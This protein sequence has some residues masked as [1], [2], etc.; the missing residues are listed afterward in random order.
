MN[1]MLRYLASK[2]QHKDLLEWLQMHNNLKNTASQKV[3]ALSSLKKIDPHWSRIERS[4]KIKSWATAAPLGIDTP[5]SEQDSSDSEADGDEVSLEKNLKTT[6]KRKHSADHAHAVKD[7]AGDRKN[8]KKAKRVSNGS[9]DDYIDHGGSDDSDDDY[10]EDPDRI[11]KESGWSMPPRTFHFD[12]WGC[13]V[14]F[15]TRSLNFAGRDCLDVG[16]VKLRLKASMDH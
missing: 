8:R 3:A 7:D 15:V 1:A 5:D 10:V 14:P 4:K 13:N 9:D 11:S 6:K 2:G 16:A 12:M